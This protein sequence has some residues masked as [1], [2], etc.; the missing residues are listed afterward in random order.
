LGV[1]ALAGGT[2]MLLAGPDA[3]APA[4]TAT[5]A[6]GPEPG[7][8]VGR[9]DGLADG[10]VVLVRGSGL[11][12]GLEVLVT[13]CG[14]EALE[15][16]RFGSCDLDVA[17]RTRTDDEGAFSVG[18]R[19]PRAIRVIGEDL[20]CAIDRCVLSVVRSG[21]TLVELA[22]EPL[23]FLPDEPVRPQLQ[24]LPRSDLSHR[25]P[26]RVRASG[27]DE[28]IR[29]QQCVRGVVI[30]GVDGWCDPVT[31][32]RAVTVGGDADVV[33]TALRILVGPDGR[34]LDCLDPAL[35]CELE[36]RDDTGASAAVRLWFDPDLPLPGPP[37]LFVDPAVGLGDRDEVR[38]VVAELLGTTYDLELCPREPGRGGA[39][40]PVGSGS[41]RGPSGLATLAVRLPRLLADGGGT[42]DCAMAP[43]CELRLSGAHPTDPAGVRSA[44]MA[45]DPGRPLL[46]PLV[47]FERPAAGGPPGIVV[48]T[49]GSALPTVALCAAG[50]PDETCRRVVGSPEPRGP[51]VWAWPGEAWFADLGCPA[52][53]DAVVVADPGYPPVRA[54]TL[55]VAPTASAGTASD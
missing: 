48:A 12:S 30:E 37:S 49:A 9:T 33:V 24:A 7:V 36:V 26:I 45:F 11:P 6:V 34:L 50:A 13:P 46:L 41:V 55:G 53:C 15:A 29:A 52:S 42:V 21:N 8:R 17:A 1:L 28:R 19:V 35:R 14:T 2:A 27:F 39:C 5:T 23:S 22:R 20:D 51:G 3:A 32:V 43:G 40:A 38:V 44:V 10:Q 47:A 25:T 4:P 18:Y 54:P 16:G 31:V